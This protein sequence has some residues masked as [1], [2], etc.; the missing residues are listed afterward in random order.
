[1]E[2]GSNCIHKNISCIGPMDCLSGNC[3]DNSCIGNYMYCII[4]KDMAN[5]ALKEGQVC[6][7]N[8]ECMSNIC[9]GGYCVANNSKDN[10]KDNGHD[11]FISD[12]TLYIAIFFIIL[13]VGI[14]VLAIYILRSIIKSH[15][16]KEKQN[17][18]YYRY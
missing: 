10:S 2:Q 8:E 4:N 3:T 7:F 12:F 15:K 1:M 14:I 6:K 11:D 5:C 16:E 18:Y 13:G 9:N 17:Q